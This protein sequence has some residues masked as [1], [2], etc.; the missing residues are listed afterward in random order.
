M[1]EKKTYNTRMTFT[2]N[3]FYYIFHLLILILLLLVE[4][5]EVIAI[6]NKCVTAN[7]R[8]C[9]HVETKKNY[10]LHFFFSKLNSRKEVEMFFEKN[11]P[12]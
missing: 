9:I 2:N 7:K 10:V 3:L 11:F 4:T 6:K 8:F 5:A 12:I 1:K